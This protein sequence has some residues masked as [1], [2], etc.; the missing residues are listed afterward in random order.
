MICVILNLVFMQRKGGVMRTTMCLL[1]DPFKD[2]PLLSIFRVKSQFRIIC[3]SLIL[4]NNQ[5][6]YFKYAYG[7]WAK[8]LTWETCHSNNLA[9]MYTYLLWKEA[10]PFIWTNLNILTQGCL[11]CVYSLLE[12]C[13][14]EK[15]TKYC[16]CI[17]AI[18]SPWKRKGPL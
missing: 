13:P 18:I 10:L 6:F 8:S 3:H 4:K 15:I 5:G 16:Q 9:M 12:I 11:L 14:V 17:L 2:F 1:A 7:P